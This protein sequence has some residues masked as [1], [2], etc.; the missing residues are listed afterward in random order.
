MV[1]APTIVLKPAALYTQGAALM[2]TVCVCVCVRVH[3]GCVAYAYVVYPGY[4]ST[5][6][7]NILVSVKKYP[8]YITYILYL[9]Y[10]SYLHYLTCQGR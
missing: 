1:T 3:T 4:F 8:I 2:A 6:K 7:I 9:Y 5:F 10:I